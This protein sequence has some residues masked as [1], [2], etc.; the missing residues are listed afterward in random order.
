MQK[1]PTKQEYRLKNNSLTIHTCADSCRALGQLINYIASNRD[2]HEPPA[3]DASSC[4]LQGSTSV[5]RVDSASQL[6][7]SPTEPPPE[8]F[9]SVKSLVDD[10]MKETFEEEQRQTP[11]PTY[12]E[13]PAAVVSDDG[14]MDAPV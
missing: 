12:S 13:A 14:E 2:L 10:A 8:V 6:S 4:D 5:E 9:D 7:Q 3:D 1:N 11:A